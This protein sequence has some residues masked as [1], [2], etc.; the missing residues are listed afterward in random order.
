MTFSQ[1]SFPFHCY[2]CVCVCACAC[3][4]TG[5]SK[6]QIWKCLEVELDILFSH[7][8]L[9]KVNAEIHRFPCCGWV[10][11]NF[12]ATR[13]TNSPLIH[14]ETRRH[15]CCGGRWHPFQS[16]IFRLHPLPVTLK[17]TLYAG[18]WAFL[19]CLFPHPLSGECVA[20]S[21]NVWSRK[22]ISL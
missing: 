8:D 19:V 6:T 18:E 3:V 12:E 22:R 5:S 15:N 9:E 11:G 16:V 7:D 4:K 17:R 14:L 13:L 10:A 2:V 20:S 21:I 1:G